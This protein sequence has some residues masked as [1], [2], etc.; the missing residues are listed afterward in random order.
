VRAH[1]ERR[2]PPTWSLSSDASEPAGLKTIDMRFRWL[3]ALLWT[4]EDLN[5]RPHPET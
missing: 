4:W 1:K 5:L 2:T 3:E